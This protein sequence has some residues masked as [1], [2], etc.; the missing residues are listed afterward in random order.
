VF[1]LDVLIVLT[2]LTMSAA[3]AFRRHSPD[4]AQDLAHCA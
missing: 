1:G 3:W 4:F 2:N